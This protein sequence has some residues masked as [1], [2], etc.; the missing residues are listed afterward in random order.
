[1]RECTTR[2]SLRS[3][4]LRFVLLAPEVRRPEIRASLA[5]EPLCL[6]PP[7]GGDPGVVAARE[8]FR[9]GAV[10]PQLRPRVLRIFEEPLGE[11]FLSR[12]SL[13]SHDS[14]QEPHAGVE[15]GE[16]RDLSAREDIIT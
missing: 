12:R 5:R 14:R 3:S 2:I 7:P 11:A 8:Y 15:Q 13:F 6:L 10:L 1:M 9:N 16:R 4:G